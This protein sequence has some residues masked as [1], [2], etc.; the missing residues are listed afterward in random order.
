MTES[1]V[2]PVA[3]PVAELPPRGEDPERVSLGM[4][5]A[6]LLAV[7]VP[8]LGVVAAVVFVWGWGFSWVD[9][10]LL[11]GMYILTAAGVTAAYHRL[12]P[13]PAFATT[14]LSPFL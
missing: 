6:S 9:L 7:I 10:R 3:D 5:V 13:H 11:L 14:P 1:T 8:F 2:V 12:F 4:R